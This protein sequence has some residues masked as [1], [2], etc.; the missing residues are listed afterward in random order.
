MWSCRKYKCEWEKVHKFPVCNFP[1]IGQ[2]GHFLLFLIPVI[3]SSSTCAF[4]I[5]NP[6]ESLLHSGSF[7]CQMNCA[8]SR[9]HHRERLKFNKSERQWWATSGYG[10]LFD[11]EVG[12][13][14]MFYQVRGKS[15]TPAREHSEMSN[16]VVPKLNSDLNLSLNPRR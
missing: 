5:L 11:R 1:L 13:H 14:W 12:L 4:F 8:V 6:S 15:E 2:D 7:S 3:S 16:M 10:R 9:A